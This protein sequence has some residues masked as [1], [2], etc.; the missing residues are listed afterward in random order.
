MSAGSVLKIHSVPILGRRTTTMTI[1][2]LGLLDS[3]PV[4]VVRNGEITHSKEACKGILLGSFVTIN[5]MEQLEL[6]HILP[7]SDLAIEGGEDFM[8]VE[9]LRG[10]MELL[11]PKTQPVEQVPII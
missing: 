1:E 7:G 3:D 2:V 9:T 10:R 4:V 8:R 5:G 11:L 6:G